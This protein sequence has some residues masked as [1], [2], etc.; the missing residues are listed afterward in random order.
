V[1]TRLRYAAAMLLG[2]ALSAAAVAEPMTALDSSDLM[3]R[4]LAPRNAVTAAPAADFGAAAAACAT[5]LG[6]DGLDMG[7]LAGLGWTAIPL[8][9]RADGKYFAYERAGSSV[10]VYLTTTFAASGQCV[11]DG[12]GTAKGQFG[13]IAGEV[14]KQVAAIIGKELKDTG[15]SSSPGGYSQGKGFLA[16][17][18]MTI[19][20]SENRSEGMS[21]RVT[22]MRRDPSKDPTSIAMAAGMAAE[23]LPTAIEALIADAKAP[24]PALQPTPKP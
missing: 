6:R 20:S 7:K 4:L 15:S 12:Y 5:T 8:P 10:R 19:V 16:D 18:L 17:D 24:E 13:A 22:L 14:K 3:K 9:A 23:Y 11:V 21:I 1:S 2:L